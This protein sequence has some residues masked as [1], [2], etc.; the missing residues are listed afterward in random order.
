MGNKGNVEEREEIYF[1]FDR[2][3]MQGITALL[4]HRKQNELKKGMKILAENQ[5]KIQGRIEMVEDEMLSITQ[6]HMEDIKELRD[7][8]NDFGTRYKCIKSA[9]RGT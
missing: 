5:D 8:N 9:N 2:I 3:G 4:N 6:T 1:R 7:D